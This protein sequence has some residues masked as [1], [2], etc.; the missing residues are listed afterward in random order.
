MVDPIEENRRAA[1]ATAE[2]VGFGTPAGCAGAAAFWSGGSLG[3]PHVQVIPPG[4]H[5]TARGVVG[6]VMMAAVHLGPEQI[7]E[8]HRRFLDRGIQVADGTDRWN[9]APA[10]APA[11]SVASGAPVKA[12]RV[13]HDSW[14]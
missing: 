2:A 11:K 1:M 6:A 12:P 4:E 3:P 10:A 14:E 5:L 13:I 7:D 8:T 9:D